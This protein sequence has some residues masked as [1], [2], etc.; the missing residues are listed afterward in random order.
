MQDIK[1]AEQLGQG[2]GH[3]HHTAYNSA[4]SYALLRQLSLAVEW[5]R[6]DP[7]FLALMADLKAQRERWKA[8]L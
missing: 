6:R 7:G 4:A 2:F 1:R 5:L 3:F 8:V